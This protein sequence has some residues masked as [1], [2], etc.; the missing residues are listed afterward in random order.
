[1]TYR[2]NIGML[3]VFS[4]E[5]FNINNIISKRASSSCESARLVHY[6]YYNVHTFV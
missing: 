2:T 5:H 4:L 6:K 3:I 1:M